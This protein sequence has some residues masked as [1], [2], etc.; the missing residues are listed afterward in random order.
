[1]TP[2]PDRGHDNGH[3]PLAGFDPLGHHDT[4]PRDQHSPGATRDS[5]TWHL[6][7][8]QRQINALL[9]HARLVAEQIAELTRRIVTVEAQ[10]AE[11]DVRVKQLRT[12]MAENTEI[13]KQIR[14]LITAGRVM[15]QAGDG[16][17]WLAKIGGQV[18]LFAAAA[19]GAFEVFVKYI[20][21][22]P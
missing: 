12:D 15:K 4:P 20:K 11:A 17:G 1:M 5:H 16:I 8:T 14:D 2:G 21:G 22:P 13:T 10:Q 3:D 9:A 19:Y 18:A 7:L 6:E